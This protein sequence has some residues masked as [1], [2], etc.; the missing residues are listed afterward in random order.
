MDPSE[1]FNLVDVMPGIAMEML[2][3]LKGYQNSSIPAHRPQLDPRFV[4]FTLNRHSE[5][6]IRSTI[7][8]FYYSMSKFEIRIVNFFAEEWD[9]NWLW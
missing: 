6:I 7:L 4:K 1:Q 2:T 8:F 9:T 3:K 5:T